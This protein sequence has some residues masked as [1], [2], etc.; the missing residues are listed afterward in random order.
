[1][2]LIIHEKEPWGDPDEAIVR[3]QKELRKANCERAVFGMACLEAFAAIRQGDVIRAHQILE[4]VIRA[5]TFAAL[6]A[7]V[8]P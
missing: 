4:A 3:L 1:M 6:V 8:D 7:K 5:E 2:G